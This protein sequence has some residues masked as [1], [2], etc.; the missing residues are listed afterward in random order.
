MNRIKPLGLALVCSTFLACQTEQSND[1]SPTPTSSSSSTEL[2]SSMTLSSSVESSSSINSSSAPSSS[3][4][5]SSSSSAIQGEYRDRTRMVAY[6]PTY[7]KL[8]PTLEQTQKISHLMYFTIKLK[9]GTTLGEFDTLSSRTQSRLKMIVD[10]THAGGAKAMVV[11]GGAGYSLSEFALTANTT[12]GRANFAHNVGVFL[13]KYNMDGV[14]IDWEFPNFPAAYDNYVGLMQALRDTLNIYSQSL[15]RKLEVS[16]AVH[17]DHAEYFDQKL[18]QAVDFL[19]IMGYDLPGPL[20]APVN[21]AEYYLPKFEARGFAKSQLVMGIPAY[22]K[23]GLDALK[24]SQLMGEFACNP[25]VDTCL[26]ESTG[27]I[28]NFNGT[29]TIGNKAKYIL[30]H[31]YGGLLMWELGHDLPVSD[32]RSLLNVISQ[33]H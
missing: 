29:R 32:T 28:F 13:A 21:T 2:S 4:N 9:L 33:T 23:N 31:G 6:F 26:V 22:G 20:H 5:E 27:Q 7:E 19:N 14:D 17:P 10:T 12:Q 1:G 15:G 11:F 16:T 25:E 8:N 30:D 24:W 3:V 18:A